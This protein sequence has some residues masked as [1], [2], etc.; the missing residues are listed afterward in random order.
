MKLKTRAR[1]T[2]KCDFRKGLFDMLNSKV[3]WGVRVL[4]CGALLSAAACN[5][6]IFPNPN[7]NPNPNGDF[8]TYSGR[9]ALVMGTINGTNFTLG[10]TGEIPATGGAIDSGLLSI[11]I[12]NVITAEI[13]DSSIVAQ[14]HVSHAE[15]SL[16]NFEVNIDDHNITIGFLRT[17]A[18]TRCTGL[19]T[20]SDGGVEIASLIIDG[21][22]HTVTAALNQV[23]T[24][25]NSGGGVAGTITINEQDLSEDDDDHSIDLT[26]NALHFDFPDF[27]VIIGHVHSDIAC[28]EDEDESDDDFVTGGGFINGPTLGNKANF[29]FA[30]G[31]RDGDLW[32]HLVYHDHGDGTKVES[33]S[34]TDYVV[35]DANTRRIEGA[36][37]VDG[38]SG[39]T[40]IVEVTDNGEP[41][42]NDEF[43]I[44]LSNNYSASGDLQGG[45]IQ[46]H[47]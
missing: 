10:D 4:S 37:E 3:L 40:F 32:G 38:V 46:L 18:E 31:T 45:N 26:V 30:G 42:T 23:I 20:S 41:G 13:V 5:I 16:A 15:A 7:P 36:A 19:E 22:P 9:A 47:D 25:N 21:T 29:G 39:F 8:D 43:S 6:D 2:L 11:N 12:A 14:N 28:G 33:L 27:D 44:E 34:I 17:F 35:V 1:E 24:V